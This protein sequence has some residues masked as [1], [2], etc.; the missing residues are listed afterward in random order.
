MNLEQLRNEHDY[1]R[2][3]AFIM[4]GGTSLVRDLYSKPKGGNIVTIAINHHANIL[5]P[6]FSV[7][8]DAHTYHFMK[9]VRPS[10]KLMGRLPISDI[11]ISIAPN[12]QNG[13]MNAVWVADYLGFNKVVLA[14]FDCWQPAERW[15]W[16]DE[17]FSPSPWDYPEVRH[18]E[19]M[20]T[21]EEVRDHLSHPERVSAISGKLTEVFGSWN[22]QN[23]KV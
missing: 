15:H 13:G 21:W 23:Q 3:L 12:W 17:T 1:S 22:S 14:G 2:C 8:E 5:H 6:H 7:V 11:D 19:I 16:H 4:G 18:R 10:T 9:D 20:S